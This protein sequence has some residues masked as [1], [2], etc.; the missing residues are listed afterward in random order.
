MQEE[1]IFCDFVSGKWKQHRNKFKFQILNETP[2]TISF[3]SIDFPKPAR[4]HVLVIPKKHYTNLEDCPKGTIHEL[5]EHV[6]LISKAIRLEHEGC[7]ILLNDGRS[8][9]Q[10]VMHAHFHVVPRDKGDK[11][12]IELWKRMNIRAKTYNDLNKKVKKLIKKAKKS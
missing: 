8:A 10:T 2:K 3:L 11:I 5:I 4:E 9:E 7:N 1:C 6:S 12:E